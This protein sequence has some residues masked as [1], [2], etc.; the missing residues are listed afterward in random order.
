MQQIEKFTFHSF[1]IQTLIIAGEPYFIGK[2]IAQVLGYRNPPKAIRDHVDAEDKLTERIVLSGQNREVIV[3]NE[4]GLYSLIL[5]SKLPTA[6]EFKR[7]V[8]A[9]VLPTIRRH[10]AY[11]TDAKI[12]QVLSDP[13]TIIQLATQLKNERQARITAQGQVADMKP[14]AIFADA[15]TV[16]HTTILIGELAKLLRQNGIDIGQN[17][18]FNWLRSNGYLICRKG[19]DWN[20]PT[21]RAAN[22][23]LFKVKETAI[24]HS[25]GTVTISKTVKVTGKGQQYFI[26]KFLGQYA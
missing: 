10:G 26:N 24:N 17:R 8:T 14:K 4:S 21:Q 7:W 6:K 2:N 12:E 16:S 20:Q 23:G 25:D 19:T 13:D 18:L 22:M 9:E 5:S 15:V 11:M 3:I 1:E